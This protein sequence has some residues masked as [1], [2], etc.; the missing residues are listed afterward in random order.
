MN[1]P[2]E[3]RIKEFLIDY[4]YCDLI[5][6]E[7]DTTCHSHNKTDTN[8][9]GITPYLNLRALDIHEGNSFE[10]AMRKVSKTEDWGILEDITKQIGD[11]TFEVELTEFYPDWPEN[12]EKGDLKV[13]HALN[14]AVNNLS[15]KTIFLFHHVDEWPAIDIRTG[16]NFIA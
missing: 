3:Q 10:E 13:I 6:A 9:M 8:L 1:N 16:R 4:R 5:Q 15:Q 11:M 2:V 14:C 7:I 12:Y